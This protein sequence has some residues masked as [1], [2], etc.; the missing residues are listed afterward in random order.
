MSELDTLE[1][2]LVRWRKHVSIIRKLKQ[3]NVN[4][5]DIDLWEKQIDMMF[6]EKIKSKL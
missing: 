1:D 4:K 6:A 3:S 2:Y 5:N